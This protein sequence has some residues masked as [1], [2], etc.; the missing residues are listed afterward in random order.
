[1]AKKPE[2][3]LVTADDW[4]AIY[5]DG[6][7]VQQNHSFSV[8][9]FFSTLEDNDVTP[10]EGFTFADRGVDGNDDFM[11]EVV[12]NGCLPTNLSDVPNE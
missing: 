12:K 11:E 5:I 7:S 1:M 3:V 8:R 10:S 9:Q 4:S 6:K 2:V